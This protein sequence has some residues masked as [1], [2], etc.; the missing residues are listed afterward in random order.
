MWLQ[1]GDRLQY[2]GIDNPRLRG[3]KQCGF[4]VAIVFSMKELIIPDSG[5]G[6]FVMIHGYG[7][8][9]EKELIIPDSGDG[10]RNL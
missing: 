8:T 9:M 5:D 1:C 10:N 7:S 6:N 4:N 3:R 2:E